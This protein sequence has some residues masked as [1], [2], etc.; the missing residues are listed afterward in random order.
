MTGLPG[1]G[2]AG[3]PGVAFVGRIGGGTNA[4]CGGGLL[5]GV[6]DG[7]TL[8]GGILAGA[9]AFGG[10]DGTAFGVTGAACWGGG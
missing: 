10:N 4:F 5:G 8:A 1:F 7:G 2:V 9:A 3:V 6:F